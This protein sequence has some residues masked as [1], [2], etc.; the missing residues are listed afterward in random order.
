MMI[1]FVEL[2]GSSFQITYEGMCSGKER[3]EKAT[4]DV[5]GGFTWYNVI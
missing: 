3:A 4:I 5:E 1:Y 2:V